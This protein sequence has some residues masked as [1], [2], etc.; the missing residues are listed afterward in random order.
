[1]LWP[2]DKPI[3]KLEEADLQCLEVKQEAF[4]FDYKNADFIHHPKDIAKH[5]ASFANH[6]GGWLFIGINADKTSNEPIDLPGHGVPAAEVSSETVYS[7]VMANLSPALMVAIQLVKLQNGN[8]VVVVHIDE[9]QDT[10]HVHKPTGRIFVRSGNVTDW[11][12]HVRDRHDLDVL[13]ARGSKARDAVLQLLE[14]REFGGRLLRRLWAERDDAAENRNPRA[15]IYR[16]AVTAVLFPMTVLDRVAPASVRRLT[17]QRLSDAD[18]PFAEVTP[19]QH[20]KVFTHTEQLTLLAVSTYGHVE[21]A[22]LLPSVT[23][24]VEFVKRQLPELTSLAREFLCDSGYL[25]P[26]GMV[27]TLFAEATVV[28]QGSWRLDDG[29]RVN[30]QL[31]KIYGE[32]SR[33]YE[34]QDDWQG[35]MPDW[36]RR[37]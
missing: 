32:L 12:D 9:S 36:I 19:W 31:S 15:A 10:P 3:Y 33:A 24:Y 37:I 11:V 4:T 34:T 18:L 27:L 29:D 2:F 6:H 14:K 22:W 26:I 7:A 20:G 17:P 13:H 5:V 35:L 28:A 21:A 25:G 23:Q 30:T 8:S 16:D 1:M